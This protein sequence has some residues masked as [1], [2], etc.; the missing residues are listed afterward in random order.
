MSYENNS[1][2][3]A[4]RTSNHRETSIV[5]DQW[6]QAAHLMSFMETFHQILL[7]CWKIIL[8]HSTRN[9]SSDETSVGKRTSPLNSFY[10][11]KISV[12]SKVHRYTTVSR[13]L[14]VV[15][16]V[17]SVQHF[18][19]QHPMNIIKWISILIETVLLIIKSIY[20]SKRIGQ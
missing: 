8:L 15:R 20:G 10:H 12:S 5:D 13:D 1:I 17:P 18:S 2:I 7:L 16:N 6:R 11:R 4:N 14:V 19:L 3:K 9:D